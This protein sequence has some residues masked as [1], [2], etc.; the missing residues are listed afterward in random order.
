MKLG[1]ESLARGAKPVAPFAVTRPGDVVWVRPLLNEPRCRGCHDDDEQAVR[2]VLAVAFDPKMLRDQQTLKAVSVTSLKYVMLSGL[3]RLV[4]RFLDDVGALGLARKL[5]LHDAEGRLYHDAFATPSVPPH[6]ARAL[7][8]MKPTERQV[9]V[10]GQERFVYTD[11]LLNELRCQSCHGSDLPVRGAIAI[12]LDTH[13]EA[14]EERALQR[15]GLIIASGTIVLM[16]LLLG[17]GLDRTVLLPVHA[18]GQVAE[19]IGKGDLAAVVRVCSDDEIDRLGQRINEMTRGLCQKLQLAKFV[20]KETLAT[21]HREEQVRLTGE[22]RTLTVL[23]SDIRGFTA[24]SETREPEEVVDMLNRF[25][26]VQAD[27]VVHHGGDIDKFVG[28]ELMARFSGEDQAKQAA[29]C[30]AAMV[31][32]VRGLNAEADDSSH[33]VEIGVGV[34]TGEMVLGTMGSEARMDFTVIGDAVNLGARL[35]SAA[36]PGEVLIAAETR[37]RMGQVPELSVESRPSITVKGKREPVPIY[38]VTMAD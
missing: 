36:A 19:Q 37:R 31:A 26:Q 2:G 3:G 25:L 33:E 35:C 28:D 29:L 20:S 30:G 9:D 38:L 1:E 12:S 14:A 21:V 32:A 24:F 4:K 23:F 22:R 34:S 5:T 27:V 10:E 17:F 16:L 8:V 15:R 11:P 7:R 6:V 13:E 18:I